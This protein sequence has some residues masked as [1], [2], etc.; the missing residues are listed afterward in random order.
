YLTVCD[1]HPFPYSQGW[2]D[3]VIAVDPMNENRV[4]AGGIDIFRSDDGGAN[5]GWEPC[6]IHPDNHAITFHPQ[7]DGVNN[8]TM[9]IGNDGGMYRTVY[10]RASVTTWICSFSSIG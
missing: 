10:A 2:Y 5:W 9:F 3:N 4:W 6:F 8:K 7:Y 1:T